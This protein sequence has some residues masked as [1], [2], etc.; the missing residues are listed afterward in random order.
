MG[1]IYDQPLHVIAWLGPEANES[2]EAIEKLI[3]IGKLVILGE[4]DRILEKIKTSYRP[5]H[6]NEP[7]EPRVWEAVREL[8]ID[9]G[10]VE[11]G[12]FRRRRGRH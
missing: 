11:Y 4:D 9:L 5:L 2:N 6:R 3:E 1:D 7:H 8:S 10:G 12:R